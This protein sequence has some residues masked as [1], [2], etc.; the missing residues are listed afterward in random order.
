M[1]KSLV[2]GASGFIG[3][4]LAESLVARGE[5]VRA[6]VRRTS[7]TDLLEGLGVELAAGDLTDVKSLKAAVRGV[8]RIYHCAGLVS[9]WGPRKEFFTA[10]VTGVKNILAAA[11]EARVGKLVHISTTDVYG[12]PN[13]PV[14]ESAPYRPRGWPYVDSKIEGER[15]VWEFHRRFAVPVTIIRPDSV[16]GPR[17]KS[18]VIEIVNLLKSGSMVLIGRGNRPAGLAYVSNVVDLIMLAADS[19]RSVGQAY[20]A[21]DGSNVT[22]RSYVDKLAEILGV[23]TPHIAIPYGPAYAAGWIMEGLYGLLRIPNRPL[24]TRLAVDIFATDLGFS[25]DKAREELGFQPRIDFL[26]GMRRV[27]TWLRESG[28]LA[29]ADPR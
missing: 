3:S 23:S 12:Y 19:E 25:I 28:L 9:D 5:K 18:F 24:L 4:H 26:E 16:Y 11:R 1:A 29:S 10:N 13:R 7:A 20:N 27:D 17:S 2:T 6:L 21:A 8:D 22:W 15:I 14:D